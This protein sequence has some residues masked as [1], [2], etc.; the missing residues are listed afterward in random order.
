MTNGSQ[1][2]GSA[3]SLLVK[4]VDRWLV[5]LTRG[6]VLLFLF[7]QLALQVPVIH[8]FSDAM[9]GRLVRHVPA[10]RENTALQLYVVPAAAQRALEIRVNQRLLR[11]GT[12]PIDS[13]PIHDGDILSIRTVK[14]HV[15]LFVSLASHD[16]RVQLPRTTRLFELNAKAP[17]LALRI[18][19]RAGIG[20]A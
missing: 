11:P 9:T 10:G 6:T 1:N 17:E 20:Q 7:A 16:W 19:V 3:L 12:Q 8:R 4:R 13:I 15:S 2:Q 14:P 18:H 5:R